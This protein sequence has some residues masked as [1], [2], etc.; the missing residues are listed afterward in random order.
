M[1]A[2]ID[3]LS[4]TPPPERKKERKKEK[5]KK[6]RKGKKE[7]NDNAHNTSQ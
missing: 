1:M 6:E 4:A 3:S 7:R 2:D 5:R